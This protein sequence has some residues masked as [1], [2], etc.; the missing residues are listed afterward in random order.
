MIQ[1]SL[2]VDFALSANSVAN[3]NLIL[4]MYKSWGCI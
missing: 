2:P 4:L 3:H 1:Q